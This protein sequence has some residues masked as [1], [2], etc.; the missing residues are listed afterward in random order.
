MRFIKL[1]T[2]MKLWLKKT[3]FNY[4]ALPDDSGPKN[5]I[6]QP[7]TDTNFIELTIFYE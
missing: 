7:L 3:A 5:S 4:L 1:N 6:I 2:D